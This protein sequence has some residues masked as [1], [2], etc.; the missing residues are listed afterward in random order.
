M[1]TLLSSKTVA[2]LCVQLESLQM[3]MAA[4][5]KQEALE[6]M[7][8]NISTPATEEENGLLTWPQVN[9]SSIS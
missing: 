3:E 6:K 7:E 2:E 1:L 9:T 8:Q 5:E 4:L